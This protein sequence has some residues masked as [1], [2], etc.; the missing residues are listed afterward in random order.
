MVLK[1]DIAIQAARK[2]MWR[3]LANLNQIGRYMLGAEKNGSSELNNDKSSG[4]DSFRKQK[5]FTA[6]TAAVF[7]P[8]NN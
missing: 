6:G 1:D 5:Q 7:H 8:I 2:Q 3:F 4:A